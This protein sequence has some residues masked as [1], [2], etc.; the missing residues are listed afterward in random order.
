MKQDIEAGQFTVFQTDLTV[1]IPSSWVVSSV[2]ILPWL[3]HP[4][5]GVIP[6]DK[7][8]LG[9]DQEDVPDLINDD[10]CN[11]TSGYCSLAVAFATSDEVCDGGC[12]IL[13]TYATSLQMKLISI[14]KC[15]HCPASGGARRGLRLAP[16]ILRR[17]TCAVRSVD[18]ASAPYCPCSIMSSKDGTPPHPTGRK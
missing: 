2:R 9:A 5:H 13:K 10:I 7:I 16:R 3:L 4:F 1:Q 14:L 6:E 18:A 11:N 8:V 12:I 17:A 15:I